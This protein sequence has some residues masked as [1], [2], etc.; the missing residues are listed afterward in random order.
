MESVTSASELVNTLS[1]CV[2]TL[3][4]LFGAGAGLFGAAR[5]KKLGAP[6]PGPAILIGGWAIMALI[7]LW[8]GLFEGLPSSVFEWSDFRRVLILL[9]VLLDGLAT[10]VLLVGLAMLKPPPSEAEEAS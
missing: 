3:A 5:A 6:G 7:A 2:Y 1:L 8:F 4:I 10:I 9:G